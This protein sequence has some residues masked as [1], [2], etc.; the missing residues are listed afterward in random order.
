VPV[1]A[2]VR[3]GL[4]S[5]GQW[6]QSRAVDLSTMLVPYQAQINQVFGHKQASHI[7]V[8][9]YLLKRATLGAAKSVAGQQ[10]GLGG[11]LKQAPKMFQPP[12]APTAVQPTQP[13]A[14][15]FK[16]KAPAGIAAARG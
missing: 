2:E 1:P 4:P 7:R 12:A 16:I 10:P 14:P 8:S 9:S 5:F 13:T 6:L 3:Q 15:D 11:H